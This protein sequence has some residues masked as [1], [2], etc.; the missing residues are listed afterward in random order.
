MINKITVLYM[1]NRFI[2]IGEFCFLIF[3]NE[4]KIGIT[5]G[6]KNKK[7]KKLSEWIREPDME[8]CFTRNSNKT[9]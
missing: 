5:Y 3:S 2:L 7:I 8:A 9:Q 1:Y 4:I 6:K